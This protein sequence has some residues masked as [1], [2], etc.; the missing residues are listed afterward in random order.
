MA[1]GAGLDRCEFRRRYSR[2][3]SALAEQWSSYGQ[4]EV[5]GGMSYELVWPKA[6]DQ[7]TAGSGI[8]SWL[9]MPL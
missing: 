2:D 6:T 1:G 5:S 3:A 9:E 8:A 4:S 7:R